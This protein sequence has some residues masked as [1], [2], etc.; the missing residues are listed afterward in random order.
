MQNSVTGRQRAL[1]DLR[2]IFTDARIWSLLAWVDIRSKYRLSTLGTF[3]ITGATAVL[4]VTIGLFYGELFGQDMTTYLPYFATGFVL[5]QFISATLLEASHSLVSYGNF[6]KGSELPIAFHVMRVVQK[7]LLVLAHNLIVIVG[8]W[9]FFRWQLT[10]YSLLTIFGLTLTFAFMASISLILG[11]FCVRFRDIPPLVQAVTQFLFF[12]T[13]VM[14]D[15]ST[16]SFGRAVIWLNPI[17]TFIVV[18]RDPFLGRSVPVEL[19]ASAT[20][21]TAVAATA[22]AAIYIRYRGRIAYWV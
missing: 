6:I 9:L 3:W 5:W 22:A 11:I 1:S 2:R 10:P 13:P 18:S 7:Q 14:W 4:A 17:A 12:A 19:F 16:V 15:P 8:I 21:M 20:A